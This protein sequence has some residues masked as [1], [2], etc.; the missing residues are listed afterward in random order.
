M[1]H[2]TMDVN[3]NER[4]TSEGDAV[5]DYGSDFSSDEIEILNSLLLEG[6]NIDR[7]ATFSLQIPDSTHGGESKGTRALRGVGREIRYRSED[8]STFATIEDK[9][10]LPDQIIDVNSGAQNGTATRI[11]LIIEF[12]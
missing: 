8:T 11:S 4:S 12:S 5:S 9:G 3:M 10:D 6:A 1:A 2:T 7:R